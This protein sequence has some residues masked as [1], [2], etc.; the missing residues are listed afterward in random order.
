MTEDGTVGVERGFLK[1][2]VDV[3]MDLDMCMC[4]YIYICVYICKQTNM[5]K[6][7]TERVAKACMHDQLLSLL[8]LLLLLPNKAMHI[9]YRNL[10]LPNK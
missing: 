7:L 2:D 4:I 10:S 5:T 9:R 8:L 1:M 3:D 6:P